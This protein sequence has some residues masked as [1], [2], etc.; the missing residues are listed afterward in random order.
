MNRRL[1]EK[2]TQL[3]EIT[4][5]L[6]GREDLLDISNHSVQGLKVVLAGKEDTMTQMLKVLKTV[7]DKMKS[8]LAVLR[9][10][11]ENYSNE[12]DEIEKILLTS[13]IRMKIVSIELK[14]VR[15]HRGKFVDT[16]VWQK[17]VMQRMLTIDIKE[18]LEREQSTLNRVLTEFKKTIAEAKAGI[19]KCDK[20]IQAAV[21]ESDDLRAVEG[22]LQKGWATAMS[23]SIA[24]EFEEQMKNEDQKSKPHG[25]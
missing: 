5:L 13:E 21:K 22:E 4:S 24:A 12:R 19:L 18:H 14:K 11:K 23:K 15:K 9:V 25:K 20:D 8:K 16:D 2:Q 1:D 3:L 10:T 7:E 17:G 6:K